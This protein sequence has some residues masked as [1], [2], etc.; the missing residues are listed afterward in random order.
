[1]SYASMLMA[2]PATP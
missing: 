2:S 1:L